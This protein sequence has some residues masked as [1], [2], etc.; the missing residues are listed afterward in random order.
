[1]TRYPHHRRARSWS[2]HL[3]LALLVGA[4]GCSG[5]ADAPDGATARLHAAAPRH[6]AGLR[7]ATAAETD[8]GDP[9]EN[10]D[11]EAR[12]EW[13][14]AYFGETASA[15]YLKYKARV[16]AAEAK[17]ISRRHALK[18]A[19]AT[20]AWVNLGPF[21]GA[22]DPANDAV[23]TDAGRLT[24]IVTDPT[25]RQIVY[26]AND[27][28]VFKSTNADPAAAGDW[29][30][31]AITD[32]LPASSGSGNI[33]VGDLA[34]SPTDPSTLFLGLGDPTF[35]P[36]SVGFFYTHDGGATWAAAGAMSGVTMVSKILPLSS[37]VVLV[38]TNNNL[39]RSVD[40][41]QTFT[42]VLLGGASGG[43]VQSLARFTD[44]TLVASRYDGNP[45]QIYYSTDQGATWTASTITG[46]PLSPLLYI[47]L[48]VGGGA[49]TV[50]YGLA[51]ATGSDGISTIVPGIFK[52][53]DSGR[54]WAYVTPSGYAYDR[55][56]AGYNMLITVDPSDASHVWVGTQLNLYRSLDGGVT[57]TNASNSQMHVDYHVAAWSKTGA[58]TLYIGN[59]GGL[60]VMRDP[61]RATIPSTTDLT[62]I[63]TRHNRGVAS[64]LVYNL[65]ST[66]AT[67]PAD[68]RYHV[69]LGLQ[70][71]GIRVRSDDGSGLGQSGLFDTVSGGDGFGSLY[72]PYQPNL[73]VGAINGHLYRGSDGKR[74][75]GEITPGELLFGVPV[76]PDASDI[77]GNSFLT[78]GPSAI[79][80]SRDF[81]VTFTALPR[82]GIDQGFSTMGAAVAASNGDVLAAIGGA[83]NG[84]PGYVTSDGGATWTLMGPLDGYTMPRSAWFDNHDPNIL[85]V[86]SV[87]SDATAHHLWKSTNRGASFTALDSPTNGLPYGLPF[88]SV[89]SDPF[90][91]NT[92]YVATEVGLYRSS[93]GGASWSRFGSGLPLVRVTDLWIAPDGSVL[94]VSTYGRGVWEIPLGHVTNTI[95][96]SIDNPTADQTVAAGTTLSFSASM[97]GSGATPTGFWLFGDGTSA[98]GTTATHT[99]TNATLKNVSYPV[100]FV[101]TDASGGLAEA[102][103]QV[104]V[105]AVPDFYIGFGNCGITGHCGFS[106]SAG[107]TTTGALTVNFSTSDP[108]TVTL[109]ASG[110]P[111]GVT[112]TFDPPSLTASGSATMTISAGASAPAGSYT[113]VAHATNSFNTHTTS[114]A[115]TVS[116]SSP[117]SPIA[118]GDFEAGTLDGWTAAG[119]T[120]VATTAHAGG[121]AAQVGAA[122]ATSGDSTVAQRFTAPSAGGQLA[123]WY[124]VH[125][126]DTVRYDWAQAT[127]TDH[128]TG[129]TT[130]VL[131]KTCT[132]SGAWVQATSALVGDHSYT[133]TLISHDDGY[134][135]D[136]T[137]VL[138][139]DVTLTEATPPPAQPLTNGDFETGSLAPWT[140]AGSTS[141]TTAAHGG[142]D[143][144]LL[145][146]A[147]TPTDG[148]SSIA[149]TFTAPS[150][151]GTLSFWYLVTCKDSVRYDWVKATLADNSAGTTSTPLAKTCTNNG[152]WVQVTAPLTASHSYTL[153]LT[154]H[155]DDYA[156][157]ETYAYFDDVIV[158]F[159]L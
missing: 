66:A 157:D 112:V 17:K 82:N 138:Y 81:G 39:W 118:N 41:A 117:S 95:T 53:A 36:P 136:P 104:T 77:T 37:S 87:A 30:W 96:A 120:S 92:V 103:R 58:K 56:Q 126:D 116:S 132:N 38:A 64:H 71:N 15:G 148:D 72:Q 73:I 143:A 127:L 134:P 61:L 6:A 59:D 142:S 150:R 133:L 33:A 19:A 100:T 91:G 98:M 54:T 147:G 55:A 125:C 47:S 149:Q 48:A 8:P 121:Y 40:G 106:V 52:S 76:I 10:D 5:S 139:D 9:D 135:G 60:A 50:G 70:D 27:G 151:G 156:G 32:N 141:I 34:M 159:A 18:T 29:S 1:M 93:N 65:S 13:M 140:R 44:G 35:G 137:Y 57:W 146:L 25:N 115:L 99:F 123:F 12:D 131:P 45:A 43:N 42:Q 90:D 46:S 94:R 80:R 124:A 63:D 67:V 111:A 154:S 69:S 128:T 108:Q 119:T 49:S 16:A 74:F 21:A 11:A 107:G 62:Y 114:A 22:S 7:P 155:D 23:W 153:T 4:A 85:Y 109:S 20:P 122:T 14:R 68:A 158:M 83:A 145:G 2:L 129:T 51:A 31:T 86:A 110:V 105:Q 89:K 79:Y 97:T 75:D 28:G 144:A 101:A 88:L 24:A 130:T 26:I 3:S 113:L 84:G 102:V 78:V 152:T